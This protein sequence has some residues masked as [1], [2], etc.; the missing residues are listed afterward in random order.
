[1]TR[2]EEFPAALDRW[3]PRD[4]EDYRRRIEDG[5]GSVRVMDAISRR[6]ARAAQAA[7][8]TPDTSRQAP[9]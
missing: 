4:W 8:R 2:T 1:M 5:E 6:R 9:A 7:P 3:T